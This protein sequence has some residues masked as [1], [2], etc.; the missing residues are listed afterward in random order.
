MI[1]KEQKDH[2]IVRPLAICEP[3]E[4]FMPHHTAEPIVEVQSDRP[5][6]YRDVRNETCKDSETSQMK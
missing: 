2:R 6:Y 5:R 3:V 1:N 4:E